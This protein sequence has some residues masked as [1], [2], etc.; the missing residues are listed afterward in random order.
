MITATSAPHAVANLHARI[1]AKLTALRPA[2]IVP[3]PEWLESNLRYA[4]EGGGTAAYSFD[5]VPALY[6]P[7]LTATSPGFSRGVLVKPIQAAATVTF[8]IGLPLWKM[9]TDPADVLITQPTVDDAQKFSKTKLDP[10]LEAS[11][12]IDGRF[13]KPDRG[14]DKHSTILMKRAIGGTL[15]MVGTNSPRMMRM[16]ST[17]L[18]VNDEVSAYPKNAGGE[19]SVL[20]KAWGRATAFDDPR[21]WMQ[22]TPLLKGDCLITQQYE[23][24]DMRILE[25]RCPSCREFFAPT[26]PMVKWHKVVQVDDDRTETRVDVA[27]GEVVVRHVPESAYLECPLCTHAIPESERRQVVSLPNIRYRVQNPTPIVTGLLGWKFNF[28]ASLMPGMRLAALVPQYLRAVQDPE[29]MQ[30][31]VNEI[32]AEVYSGAGSSLDL[33]A[34]KDR[35]EVY[36]AEVPRGAGYLTAFV[37]VQGDR[38]E[39]LVVGWGAA[40]ESWVIGLVRLYGDPSDEYDPCWQQLTTIRKRAYTHESGAQLYIQWTGIDRGGHAADAVEAYAKKYQRENVI[41]TIG[42]N[43]FDKPVL[44]RQSRKRKDGQ[45]RVVPLYHIGTDT[46][47]DRL[48]SR[49]K[50]TTGPGAIH[51]PTHVPDDAIAQL[52]AEVSFTRRAKAGAN[53]GK[54]VRAYR[55]VEDRNELIDLLV[56]CM[57]MLSRAGDVVRTNLHA[58]ALRV[59]AEGE[60]RGGIPASPPTPSP[61]TAPLPEVTPSAERAT[62]PKPRGRRVLSKGLR[63]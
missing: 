18:I 43:R 55:Q 53:A 31:F 45:Q 38:I 7:F 57:A 30:Q 4:V 1:G 10:I 33:E 20:A 58:I 41:Q 47:K 52:G 28:Y 46:A 35:R 8:A 6:E 34:I 49:L 2:P 17:P 61:F 54:S 63:R 23:Q 9:C 50:R 13:A 39:V 25:V 16:S 36:P 48:F 19:G 37:D 15:I 11:P 12:V 24:S 21:Q 3:G 22:S 27:D 51:F 26:W 42:R 40:Q 44:I 60:A 29:E 59:Q 14:R 5:N 62:L 32:E 56:G